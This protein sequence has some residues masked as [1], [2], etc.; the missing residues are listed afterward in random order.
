[1]GCRYEIY[2]KSSVHLLMREY[3]ELCIKLESS[4]G[5]ERDR[6]RKLLKKGVIPY[7]S[8][9]LASI[10]M[11]YP[12]ADMESILKVTERGRSI[13]DAAERNK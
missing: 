13:E 12:D 3:R 9:V 7:I 4:E 1:M 11:M 5:A 8:E 6:M 2:T 10:Q